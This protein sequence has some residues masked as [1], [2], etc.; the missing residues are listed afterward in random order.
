MNNINSNYQELGI[1]SSNLLTDKIGSIFDNLKVPW[2]I[3]KVSTGHSSVFSMP[4]HKHLTFSNLIEASSI[5][6]VQETEVVHIPISHLFLQFSI[7]ERILVAEELNMLMKRYIITQEVLQKVPILFSDSTDKTIIV[8]NSPR[9]QVSRDPTSFKI[10][11]NIKW[12]VG[13]GM[14]GE[15]HRKITT[16][17]QKCPKRIKCVLQPSSTCNLHLLSTS[18]RPL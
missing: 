15:A 8:T 5:K 3:F 12:N 13:V 17:C 14:S 4:L 2:S 9:V 16:T 18:R 1:E 6:D 10:N 11:Y 7:D